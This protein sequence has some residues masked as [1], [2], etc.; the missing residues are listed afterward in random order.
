MQGEELPSCREKKPNLQAEI[1]HVDGTLRVIFKAQKIVKKERRNFT[2]MATELQNMLH[3]LQC[4]YDLIKYP[5][6]L[7]HPVNS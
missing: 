3:R 4:M 6:G 5:L 1:V 2:V 7:P